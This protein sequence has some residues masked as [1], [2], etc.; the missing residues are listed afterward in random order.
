MRDIPLRG[1]YIPGVILVTRIEKDI[2]SHNVTFATLVHSRVE[3]SLYHCIRCRSNF[4]LWFLLQL[5]F[6]ITLLAVGSV[7]FSNRTI[8]IGFLGLFPL[9]RLAPRNFSEVGFSYENNYLVVLLG[10]SVSQ[11]LVYPCLKFDLVRSHLRL[12]YNPV[13]DYSGIKKF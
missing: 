1:R 5:V 9:P 7:K 11:P 6:K 2:T 8:S 4:V 13:N 10:W 12:C 3:E